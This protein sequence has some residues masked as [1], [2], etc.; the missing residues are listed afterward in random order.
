MKSHDPIPY[1]PPGFR[2]SIGSPGHPW[3]PPP[4][5]RG[6]VGEAIAAIAVALGYTG[7]AG[8]LATIINVA[9]TVA[10]VAYS[11]NQ[12][13]KAKAEATR[14][15]F[16]SIQRSSRR[17][18]RQALTPRRIIYGRTRI[19]GPLIFAH[20]RDKFEAHLL[21]ALAGHEIQEVESV[22]LLNDQLPYVT[23]AGPTF[24]RVSGKYSR[25]IIIWTFLGT[26]TQDIGQQMRTAVDPRDT[27]NLGDSIA[28]DSV[29]ETTDDFKGI[30]AIY[31]VTKAF[32]VTWEG[33][34]PEF[35]AIVKGK[36]LYDPRT[37]TTVWSRNPALAAADYLVNFLGFP[38]ASID[39]DAL[40]AAANICDQNVTLK[41][42]GTEKRYTA[43]GVFI[44]DQEHRDVLFTLA[45]AMAG[46]IRYSSGVWIIEAGAPKA[47]T[48]DTPRFTES[49]VLGGYTVSF[50]RPDRSLPNAVR[51]NFF[52]EVDWQPASFPQYEDAAAIAAEGAVNW[53]DLD[54]PLTI[55]HTM[56]QR[57]ARIE[58]RRARARRQLSIMLDLRGLLVRPGD[59]VTYHAP[60][61]G[62]EETVF[63]VDAFTFARN[64]DALVTRLD[65]VE[66][67]ATIFDWT[68]ATD[69]LDLNRGEATID[70]IRTRGVG[71]AEYTSTGL[72]LA[73]VVANNRVRVNY[74]V[75][76]TNPTTS[77]TDLKRVDLSIV[78]YVETTNGGP[79]IRHT[80]S[81]LTASV[82]NGS[83]T[84]TW[85]NV[86][87]NF[88]AG[89]IMV[90]Y[91]L[92]SASTIQ[93]FFTNNVEGPVQP[94]DP[95]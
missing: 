6:G 92:T 69:E 47:V 21:V 58:L 49:D 11:L 72:D 75:T 63:E 78:P 55:S 15:Q 27:P 67:D 68:A 52:D 34:S 35:S 38:Y 40:V 65:L 82:T 45:R 71:D 5:K 30:A 8:T 74:T 89:H 19:G 31:A 10:S 18:F 56:A 17:N 94:I 26:S 20:T 76:W 3:A 36:K 66:Y 37:D 77:E 85:N 16:E 91:G 29:I 95:A 46:A 70:S 54:L 81:T 2:A 23:T 12:A 90:G 42:G 87:V 80:G 59:L 13:S 41:A 62:L 84:R 86:T 61:I 25:T 32:S 24:G 39:E 22:W 14:S 44:A 28:I 53:L 1:L 9:I 50:D 93:A 48:V 73:D 7:S 88:P 51:G 33:Q 79:V 60:E 43:D 64:G 57:I 4:P 83:E